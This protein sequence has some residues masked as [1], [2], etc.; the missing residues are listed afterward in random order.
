M[1]A[2]L[3]EIIFY[4]K[5]FPFSICNYFLWCPLISKQVMTA[6][7]SNGTTEGHRLIK[8]QATCT[9]LSRVVNFSVPSPFDNK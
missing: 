6:L 2:I 5:H 1:Q 3:K 9:I 4:I 7:Y 8:A